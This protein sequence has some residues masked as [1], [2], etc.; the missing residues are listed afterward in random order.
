VILSILSSEWDVQKPMIEAKL[1]RRWPLP[2]K[3]D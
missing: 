2:E 1:S 3:L